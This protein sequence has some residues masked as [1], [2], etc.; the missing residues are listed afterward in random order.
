MTR[1]RRA[2]AYLLLTLAFGLSGCTQEHPT[3][4]ESGSAGEPALARSH[5]PPP[6]AAASPRI[7][8]LIRDRWLT[9][10]NTADMNIADAIYAAGFAPHIPGYPQVTDLASYKIEAAS[11]AAV[12]PDFQVALEDLFS[13]GDRVVGRF[14]A[15]GR[16]PPG[17]VPGAPIPPEGTPYTNTWI[18]IFRF[19]AGKIAEEWWQFDLLGV[20]QQLGAFPGSRPAYTWGTASSVTGD[21][22]LPPKNQALARRAEQVWNSGNMVQAARTFSPDYVHHD[23]VMPT[24]TDLAAFEAAIAAT[25][26][27]FPDLRVRIDDRVV[28]GDRVAVRRT[29]TGTHEGEFFGIPAT[30]RTVR[31]TGTTIYRVA[32]GSIVES[33][34]S[35]DALGLMMQLTG[36][37]GD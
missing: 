14:T 35:Y 7:E 19:E 24:V 32:D 20:M 8:A 30:G 9:L 18:I 6:I 23:P 25:R 28:S 27:A 29:V 31:W 5:G 12:V 17:V 16:M 36:M 13:Q 4:V 11:A 1:S 33:W 34:W 26:I 22:G 2:A 3:A 15:T 10:M 37:S 21:P